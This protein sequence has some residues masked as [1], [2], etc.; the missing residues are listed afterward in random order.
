VAQGAD[1]ACAAAL[2]IADALSSSFA[3]HF[4]G[5]GSTSR[6]EVEHIAETRYVKQLLVAHLGLLVQALHEQH[7]GLPAAA[8][9]QTPARQQQ[10]QE[11]PAYHQELLTALH[12]ADDVRM[13]Y[14][15]ESTEVLRLV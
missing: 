12:I 13:S 7:Q 11:V 14:N 6:S 4:A 15:P 10:Q 8:A 3:Q 9:G 5:R 1:S 2:E